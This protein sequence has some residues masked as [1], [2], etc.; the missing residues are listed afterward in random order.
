[1]GH[2]SFDD[3][4]SLEA[5]QHLLDRRCERKHPKRHRTLKRSRKQREMRKAK[6]LA[7]AAEN[8]RARAKYAA[9]ARAYW[10]GLA[11]EHPRI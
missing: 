9:Q 2:Q 8:R 11:D 4:N 3:P 10:S 1:M 6:G 5:R 7:R